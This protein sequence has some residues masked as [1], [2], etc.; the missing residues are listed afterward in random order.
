MNMLNML[1]INGKIENLSKKKK[2]YVKMNQMAILDLKFTISEIKITQWM[3]SATG[4]RG[5][6][7][8]SELKEHNRNYSI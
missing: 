6:R 3:G 7:K 5:K 8:V 2:E 1:E 4:W